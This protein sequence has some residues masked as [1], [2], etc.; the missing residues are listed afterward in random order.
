MRHAL[1]LI[2]SATKFLDIRGHLFSTYAKYSVKQIFLT[3]WYAQGR[4][5]CRD[6][7]RK[8]V[9]ECFKVVKVAFEKEMEKKQRRTKILAVQVF[10]VLI[11]SCKYFQLHSYSSSSSNLQTLSQL[12][13]Y[14]E[15]LFYLPAR[16]D[17]KVLK[18]LGIFSVQF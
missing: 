14:Q 16:E 2:I 4:D 1:V 18:F 10:Q 5:T 6:K 9:L 3:L 8:K 12:C 13:V 17:S 11:Y 15:C 7:L